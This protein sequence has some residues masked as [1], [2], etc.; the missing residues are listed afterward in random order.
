MPMK[1]PRLCGHQGCPNLIQ[2]GEGYCHIHKTAHKTDYVRKHPEYNKL[3]TSS[4]WQAYRHMFLTRNPL[5]VNHDDMNYNECK[6]AA[7]VLDHIVDHEGDYELF[8]N[9]DNHQAMCAICH[10]KKTAKDKGWGK[11]SEDSRPNG[12]YY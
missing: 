1:A 8:W 2:V 4:R 6:R 9:P 12:R 10:N 5:C 3:Y 11:K 7:T